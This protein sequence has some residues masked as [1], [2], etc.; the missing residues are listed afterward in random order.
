MLAIYFIIRRNNF[1]YYI[2]YNIS[3]IIIY[4]TFQYYNI[5]QILYT[6]LNYKYLLIHFET[7]IDWNYML[8]LE[9]NASNNKNLL[10]IYRL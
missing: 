10:F 8:Q 7:R 9:L 4:I 5:S 1:K 3:N 6:I 2:Y